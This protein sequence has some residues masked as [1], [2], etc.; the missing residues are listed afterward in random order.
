M[1]AFLLMLLVTAAGATGTRDG[2]TGVLSSGRKE[3]VTPVEGR[4]RFFARPPIMRKD[5]D[6]RKCPEISEQALHQRSLRVFPE[7][8]HRMPIVRPDPEID[9]RKGNILELEFD[10]HSLGGVVAFYAIVHFTE[11]Q[12]ETAFCEA[13]RVLQPGGLFLFPYHNGEETIRMEEFH[14]K[15][16]DLDIMFFTII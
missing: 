14:G 7:P 2:A 10:N 3:A 6:L 15:K 4:A 16:L 5:F 12:V 11:E 13:F 9:F 8:H 1:G